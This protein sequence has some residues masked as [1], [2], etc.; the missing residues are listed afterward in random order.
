MYVTYK[1]LVLIDLYVVFVFYSMN[2]GKNVDVSILSDY[3]LQ[4]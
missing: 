3:S 2:N 4:L 1:D